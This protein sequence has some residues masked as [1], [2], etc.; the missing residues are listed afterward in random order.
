MTWSAAPL[1]R[2]AEAAALLLVFA[3]ALL[4]LPSP[5][6][7]HRTVTLYEYDGE[8]P[9]E[10]GYGDWCEEDGLHVHTYRLDPDEYAIVEAD[11][12]I[13]WVGDAV[14]RGYRGDVHWYYDPHPLGRVANHWCVIDGPHAHHWNAWSWDRSHY[15]TY[16]GYYVWDGGWDDWFW[17][18]WNTYRVVHWNIYSTRIVHHHHHPARYYFSESRVRPRWDGRHAGYVDSRRSGRDVVQ[19][20]RHSDGYER[21]DARPRS[22]GSRPAEEGSWNPRA[23][24]GESSRRDDRDRSGPR[25]GDSRQDPQRSKPTGEIR[26]DADRRD[27]SKPSSSSRTSERGSYD[28]P[29]SSTST[30]D[31]TYESTT[32]RKEDDSSSRRSSSSSN[33]TYGEPTSRE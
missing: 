18:S 19:P 8:H 14:V 26:A 4:A 23:T 31:R 29:R 32:R 13:Y 21:R 1:P 7:A 11:G 5:A 15:V 2:P 10:D 27:T 25:D 17:W 33:R 30:R 9:V 12:V 22:D 3:V 28:S 24:Y 16:D 20:R 6:Q